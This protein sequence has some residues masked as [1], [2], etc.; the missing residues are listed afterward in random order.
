MIS[1]HLGI[2]TSSL[3]GAIDQIQ[4]SDTSL[5]IGHHILHYS[6]VLRAYSERIHHTLQ[7]NYL[8]GKEILPESAHPY[9]QR[10]RR[11]SKGSLTNEAPMGIKAK[12]RQTKGRILSMNLP[13]LKHRSKELGDTNQYEAHHLITTTM[14][15]S[16]PTTKSRVGIR[17]GKSGRMRERNQECY[18]G[19]R[20]SSIPSTHFDNDHY[21]WLDTDGDKPNWKM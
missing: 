11:R 5:P 10:I 7:S 15:C 16:R 19:M 13:L 4:R 3:T 12:H 18:T 1:Q 9:S 20:S 6:V 2:S 14:G 8:I 21:E 17:T